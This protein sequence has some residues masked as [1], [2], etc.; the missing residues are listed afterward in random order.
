MDKEKL[1]WKQEHSLEI[2]YDVAHIDNFRNLWCIDEL[3]DVGSAGERDYCV[4]IRLAPS[5]EF[6][7]LTPEGG[8]RHPR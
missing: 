2:Q 8:F 5:A 4:E 6:S 1:V 7:I 3:E